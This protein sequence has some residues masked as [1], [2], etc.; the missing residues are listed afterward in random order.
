M[1][2]ETIFSTLNETGTPNFAP[3]GIEWDET[4]VIV[5]PFRTSKTC[6]NLLSGGYGVANVSDNVLEYVRSALYNEILPSFPAVTIPGAILADTCSWLE[7]KMVSNGGTEERAEL[8]LHIMHSGRQRDFMGFCRA[9]NAVIEATILATR[10]SFHGKNKVLDSLNQYMK[11]VE[12]TG[13][14]IEKE[15]FQLVCDYVNKRGE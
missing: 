9:R 13:S 10:L 7:L 1:I 3:M 15:S 6:R 12:K 14:E 11:V 2:I 5:R 8:K 4:S